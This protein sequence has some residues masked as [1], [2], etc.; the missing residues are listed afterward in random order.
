MNVAV[1][2]FTL[3]IVQGKYFIPKYNPNFKYKLMTLKGMLVVQG[4]QGDTFLISTHD[5]EKSKFPLGQMLSSKKE[6]LSGCDVD[7]ICV[8]K[9]HCY[10]AVRDGVYGLVVYELSNI[11]PNRDSE[12]S[13]FKSFNFR[14]PMYCG[15]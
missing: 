14:F 15:L 12:W 11:V 9:N 3:R 4:E 6:T 5:I 7:E 1:F 8:K 2:V 13:L 10:F